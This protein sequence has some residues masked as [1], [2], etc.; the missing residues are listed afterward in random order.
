MKTYYYKAEQFLPTDIQTAWDF[1]SSAKNLAVITPPELDFR[2]LTNLEDKEI[3]EGMII[4]YTVKPLFGIPLHW[5]TEIQKI[6]KPAM[7]VDKQVKGP[8]K[9]WEH[10]H[11]FME[12]ENGVLMHDI[13]KYQIPFGFL[14]TLAHSLIIRKKIE[15]IFSFR[16][17]ILEKFFPGRQETI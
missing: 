13:V 14:G 7:F 10:T 11:T 9:L 15:H 4:D 17:E 5:K 2:I 6:N 16:K 8:Y 3:Y 1:F 12:K